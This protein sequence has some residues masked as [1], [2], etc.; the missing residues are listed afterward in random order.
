MWIRSKLEGVNVHSDST[1]S[2]WKL[3]LGGTQEGWMGERSVPVTMAV[4]KASAT[5]IAQAPVPVPRSRIC[6]G[7]EA[8]GA[9]NRRPPRVLV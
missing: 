8:M 9:R 7:S 2:I 4:G 3:R 6:D 5:S 1:S